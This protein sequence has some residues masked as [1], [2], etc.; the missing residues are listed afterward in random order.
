MAQHGGGR[1]GAQALG[2]L[3]PQAFPTLRLL[4]VLF[5]ATAQAS[6]SGTKRSLCGLVCF[7]SSLWS[8]GNCFPE[9]KNR[10]PPVPQPSPLYASLSRGLLPPANSFV[11]LALNKHGFL[12]GPGLHGF[13]RVSYISCPFYRQGVARP[14][15]QASVSC[16][17]SDVHRSHWGKGTIAHS[18]QRQES[19][20]EEGEADKGLLTAPQA[21]SWPALLVVNDLWPAVPRGW[22]KCPRA[23]PL[24]WGGQRVR[25]GTVAWEK[26]DVRQES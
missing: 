10:S 1:T 4:F 20:Q 22:L 21:G 13:C 6:G 18:K 9:V 2:F 8:G 19:T 7:G 3:A 23:P 12:P 24:G 11:F 5:S 17:P 16:L 15:V 26:W 25:G 14:G